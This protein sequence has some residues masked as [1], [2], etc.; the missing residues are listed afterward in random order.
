MGFSHPGGKTREVGFDR[1]IYCTDLGDPSK[2]DCHPEKGSVLLKDRAGLISLENRFEMETVN[3]ERIS[4]VDVHAHLDQLEDLSNS[5]EEAQAT[6][7]RGIIGVGMNV[8]SNRKILR[9]AEESKGYV[10]PAIGYHPWELKEEEVEENLS[11]LRNHLG[12]CIALGEIGLNDKAKMKKEV[13]WKVFR[14]L[15]TIALDFNKPVILH[16]RFSHQHVLRIV[17]EQGIKRAVFHW[18]SGPPPVLEEI[19]AMGY[20]ISATPALMYSPPHQEA[21]KQT[22]LGRILLETDAPVIYQGRES[23]PKDVRITLEEVARLKGPDPLEVSR[24]T[25]SNA[26][27]FFG[28]PF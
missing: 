9:I 25:T 28:A 8:E 11:F 24:Q 1:W 26:S 4:S 17:K 6:G 21:I 14:E 12:D 3:L 23:R 22:P 10:S 2:F 20:F 27:R 18:Y 19:L 13:Q 5:L 7:V 16:C 15:L